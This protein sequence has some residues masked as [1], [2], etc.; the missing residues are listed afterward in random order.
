MEAPGRLVK[1]IPNAMGK[2]S[3]GSNFLTIARYIS[4]HDI[5]IIISTRQSEAISAKP[6]V[7][8]KSSIASIFI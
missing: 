1:S 8:I 5:N 4:T 6:V 3:I 7:F 2:S